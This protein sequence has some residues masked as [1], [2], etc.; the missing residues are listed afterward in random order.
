M[1]KVYDLDGTLSRLNNTF[2]FIEKYHEQT[3]LG[4][5]RIKIAR[6]LRRVFNRLGVSPLLKRRLV[7]NTYFTGLSKKRLDSFYFD[8]YQEI[9]LEQLTSLGKK[10]LEEDNSR[11]I[12]LTGCT[13]VPAE[14]ISNLFNFSHCISTELSNAADF[15]GIVSVDTYGDEKI[16]YIKSLL[17]HLGI[18]SS[19]VEYYTD[20]VD[21]EAELIKIFAK[22]HVV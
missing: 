7:I 8:F 20:D 6:F 17:S 4:R 21:S 19:E 22:T 13:S 5:A 10:V 9:F 18:E 3:F 12:L 1:I 2:D 15:V 16:Y 11:N 14:N